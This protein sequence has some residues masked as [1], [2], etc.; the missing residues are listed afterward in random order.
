VT[1]VLSATL[2]LVIALC[3]GIISV[4]ILRGLIEAREWRTNRLGLA[5][6]GI[7]YTC[8]VHHGMH[9][10]HMLEPTFGIASPTG[11]AMRAAFDWHTVAA[12]TVGAAVAVYYLSLRHSYRALL[13]GPK[14]FEDKN[15]QLLRATLS[16]L[17][18]GVVLHQRGR[19]VIDSNDAASRI[20]GL[21]KEEVFGLTESVER[22]RCVRDDGTPWTTDTFPVA[23][24]FATGEGHSRVTI[25]VHREDDERR[26][27]SC[28]TAP[29]RDA[30]GA[31]EYVVSTFTDVTAER[32]A[33]ERLAW[34]AFH[35]DLTGLANRALLFDRLE[36]ALARGG[37]LG[38]DP[39]VL[40]CDLDEFKA[41]NDRYGH[42]VG[43]ALLTAVAERLSSVVRDSDTAA[44]W[45]GDE[46]VVLAEGLDRAAVSDLAERLRLAIA[47]PFDLRD[48]AGDPVPL[49]VTLSVGIAL[50]G[51]SSGTVLESADLA[52]YEA[53]RRGRNQV[54][55]AQD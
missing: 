30:A 9:T 27:V 47:A 32:E 33:V 19:G 55:S 29:L 1:W 14:M 25:G 13:H 31:V 54:V 53:K 46:F 6:A 15:G 20:L 18:E 38:T 51:T 34:R 5:T 8:A 7:F 35:D 49:R 40:F 42:T 11:L 16:A 3:Y 39:A 4:L 45:G 2:N 52:L 41:V 36:Q 26:W 50:A 21:S 43:D 28:T 12:D 48:D 24:T 17:E 10:L 23:V 22:W 44:R 37:R